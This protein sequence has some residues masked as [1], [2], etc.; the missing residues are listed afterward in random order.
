M[1]TC[2]SRCLTL[3]LFTITLVGCGGGGGG[4]TP[5]PPGTL[6]GQGSLNDEGGLVDLGPVEV[7]VAANGLRDV[8]AFEARTADLPAALPT[9]VVQAGNPIE[10]NVTTGASAMEEPVTLT[11]HPENITGGANRLLAVAHYD[12]DNG[13]YEPLTVLGFDATTVTVESRAFSV[14]IPVELILDSLPPTYTVP[15]YV[16]NQNGWRINNLGTTYL[17]PG[18]NCL[19]MSAYSIWFWK[20]KPAEKLFTKYDDIAAKIVATRAH[21]AQSQMW[22]TRQGT[23]LRA[24][25]NEIK[26]GQYEKCFLFY[27]NKPVIQ[28]MKPRPHA[29][30]AYGYVV[31]GFKLYDPNDPGA[32]V[33]IP[34]EDATGFGE[35][36]NRSEF[37]LVC[38]PS[39]GRNQDFKDIYNDAEA[40]F[41][42]PSVNI[43]KPLDGEE[44]AGREVTIEGTVDVATWNAAIIFVGGKRFDRIIGSD[45]K[46]D[47]KVPL[48]AG[49]NNIT[50]LAGTS[51]ARQS[52][53]APGSGV[54]SVNVKCTEASRK[55]LVTMSWNQDSSDVDLYVTEPD[56]ETSWYGRKVT[57][58]GGALDVD[59][60]TGRGPEHYTLG[61]T[62]Q[63]GVY[64]VYVH[65]F[66]DKDSNE[67]AFQRITGKITVVLDEGT[68][69][70]YQGDN[71]F[72][73]TEANSQNADPGSTGAGWFHVATIDV[74]NSVVF[75]HRPVG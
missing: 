21:L 2:I 33:I 39:T 71:A 7:E 53:V 70:R 26:L 61:E 36:D 6:L 57:P 65:Y 43:T 72:T 59:N 23:E 18:G 52:S 40:G 41:H 19:G 69:D 34:W 67:D 17:T 56:N 28:T 66:R 63:D 3:F 75:F 24:E 62:A 8:V 68:E 29:G 47:L 38:K 32:Q 31:G 20:E 12:E 30:V 45:R 44:I 50:V 11:F 37:S 60:T 42:A 51:L 5:P 1:S 54:N 35:Y 74:V 4:T 22:G 55:L 27:F 25:M 15:N 13:E 9:G 64:K 46:F 14:F 48:S 73:L 58:S 49:D 10:I 16:A